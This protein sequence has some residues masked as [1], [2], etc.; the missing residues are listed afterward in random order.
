MEINLGINL[1]G[2][3][4]DLQRI[5]VLVPIRRLS[6][7]RNVRGL[8]RFL[9]AGYSDKEF[10]LASDSEK[11]IFFDAQGINSPKD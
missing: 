11:S 6:L 9:G 5:H 7:N 4:E 3:R 8:R 1:E 10:P 2:K